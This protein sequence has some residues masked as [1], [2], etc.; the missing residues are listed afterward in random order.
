[1]FDL[2]NLLLSY[3]AGKCNGTFEECKNF[4]FFK[5][6]YKNPLDVENHL[7]SSLV[8]IKNILFFEE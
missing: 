7:E 3:A 2:N 5:R 1:M 4:S 8:G 6:C